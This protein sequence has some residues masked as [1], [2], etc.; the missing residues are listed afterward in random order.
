M[1]Y[2]FLVRVQRTKI[3][4]SIIISSVFVYEYTRICLLENATR[5]KEIGAVFH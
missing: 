2:H 4:N 1:C 3:V 5:R